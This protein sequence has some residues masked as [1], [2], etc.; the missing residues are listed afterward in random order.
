MKFL[1]KSTLK[2]NSFSILI[3]L[4]IFFIFLNLSFHQIVQQKQK[5]QMFNKNKS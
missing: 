3:K 5:K 4:F 2:T 1:S